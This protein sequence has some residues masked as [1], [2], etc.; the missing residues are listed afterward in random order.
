MSYCK[1]AEKIRKQWGAC[2]VPLRLGQYFVN[3]YTPQAVNP[4]LF[5]ETDPEVAMGLI[6]QWLVDHHYADVLPSH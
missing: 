2:A 6:H 4:T 1:S 5:Y 3:K